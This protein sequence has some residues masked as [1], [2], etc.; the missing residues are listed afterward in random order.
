MSRAMCNRVPALSAVIAVLIVLH[1]NLVVRPPADPPAVVP[2]IV[3]SSLLMWTAVAIAPGTLAEAFLL[4][5]GRGQEA[6]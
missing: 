6:D 2:G 4:L 5:T 3:G 1:Y